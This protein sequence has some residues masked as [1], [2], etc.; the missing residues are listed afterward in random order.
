MRKFNKSL[1]KNIR[2]EFSQK[3]ISLLYK[4]RHTMR[5]TKRRGTK[6]RRLKTRRIRTRRSRT[7]R[8]KMR[9]GTESEKKRERLAVLAEKR[10][11]ARLEKEILDR[12]AERDVLSLLDKNL[13][14]AESADNRYHKDKAERERE[15]VSNVKRMNKE[16][17]GQ[18]KEFHFPKSV[19][20]RRNEFLGNS[21]HKYGFKNNDKTPNYTPVKDPVEDE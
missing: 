13:A 14:R 17:A 4:M 18:F 5:R 12:A 6:T 3:N 15:R 16:Y 21:S 1:S 10:E 7:H 2:C 11:K 9:G 8:K 19:R 20:T